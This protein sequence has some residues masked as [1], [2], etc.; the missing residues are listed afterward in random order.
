MSED[1]DSGLWL[2]HGI[3]D[4]YSSAK[5]GSLKKYRLW[6]CFVCMRNTMSND[7]DSGLWL[8]DGISEGDSFA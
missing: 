2:R 4:G 7:C 5:S 8:R 6:F 3:S 1:C